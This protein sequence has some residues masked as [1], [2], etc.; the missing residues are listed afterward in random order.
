[1]ASRKILIVEDDP[2]VRLAM[3]VRLKAAHYDTFFA[4]DALSSIAEAH[5]QQPDLVILDLG[6]PGGDGYAV[7]ARLK[8]QPSL[9]A[10]PIIVVSARDLH[11]NKPQAI[12]AG[13]TLYLQKPVDNAELMAIIR[14][15]LGEPELPGDASATG[16]WKLL[17]SSGHG[18]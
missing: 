3:Q 9:A 6:L 4:T 13:A 12:A 1:M 10:I 11:A 8:G 14:H 7:I 16:N 17:T 15:I 18:S 2:D 5:K